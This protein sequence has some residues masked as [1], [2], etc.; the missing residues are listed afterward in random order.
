MKKSN[1]IG[2]GIFRETYQYESGHWV[3]EYTVRFYKYSWFFEVNL[4]KGWR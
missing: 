4:G 1:N 2:Y 3:H